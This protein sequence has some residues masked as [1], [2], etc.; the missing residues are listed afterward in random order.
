MTNDQQPCQGG[1]KVNELKKKT[2]P[3][4]RKVRSAPTADAKKRK[5]KV[6]AAEVL[7]REKNGLEVIN[8]IPNYIRDGWE[9][10]PVNERDRLKWVG[11]FYRKQTPGAFMMR[12]RMSS[13]FSNAE[14]FRAI[15]EISEA[16][17]PGFVDLTTRQQVQLRGFAIENVQHI[18]N[19]LEAV[20]LGSLQT[21]FDNIRGVIGCP[22]AGLTPNELFDASHVGRE[23]TNLIVGNKEFTDIPRKFN[24][25]ITGCLDN[26]TH[27]ASQDIALTPA[28][29]KIDG[30]EMKGFNVAVGGKMG[31][32]GYTLAQPLDVFIVPEEASVL[33]ADITLIFRDHG[34]RTARNKS[35][36]AFL[37]AD[38]GVEKFRE[39]LESRRHRKQPLLTAGKDMRGKNKTDHTGIFSQKEPYLNYVGL[40]VPVGRI[41]TTQLF[42]V[43]RLADEY[44]NGDIRLTQGQNLI[45]P[46]VP[47]AEIGALTAEPLLQE[48]RYDPSEV[49][50]GMVSCTGIDYCH[51]SLIETKERAMEAIRHLEAKLGNTKPLTI[52]WSGC[53]NGCGNHAAADIGLL[54]KKVKIDGIVTD[55][56]DVFLKGDA[57]ANPK[58]APK[59]LE[60]VPCDDL[61][62]VLE[63][64]VPYL[65]RR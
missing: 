57:S 17:G 38:W 29:K 36:L 43:A 11:V 55:A 21:G 4:N 53:P 35:R 1:S 65:S 45:I 64:L 60:N 41:T 52:H 7:K 33:C 16:H 27:S 23:F 63:G 54:G 37:I 47:D 5:P 61:P 48:L 8:D 58:V 25:G 15:A 42:E 20:G 6:N 49:M 51:F 22:V 19:R 28:V 18:W 62:A 10:I 26:C 59:V 34:P 2:I 31:S 39:E 32:G 40:V 24:V 50:R 9:S 56:V 44:G 13:G 3:A 12:L 46:N 30:R 14:Q